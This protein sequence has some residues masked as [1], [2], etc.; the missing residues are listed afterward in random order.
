MPL[1]GEDG[2]SSRRPSYRIDVHQL[3]TY[4]LPEGDIMAEEM[5]E[6]ILA[7]RRSLFALLGVKAAVLAPIIEIRLGSNRVVI[8]GGRAD[9]LIR[10]CVLRFEI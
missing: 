1:K 10:G 3:H 8:S 2:N 5:V 9:A 7:V 4:T 6:D